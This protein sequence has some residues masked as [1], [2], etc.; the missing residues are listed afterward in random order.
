MMAT[1]KTKICPHIFP[2]V[3]VVWL[4]FAATAVAREYHVALTG[5]G[6]NDGSSARPLRNIQTAAE[7]VLPGDVVTVHTGIYRER[8]DPP[9]GGTSDRKRIVFQA[10]PGERVEISGAEVVTNWTRVQDNIWRAVLPNSFFGGFNPFSDLIHGDWFNPLGRRHHTGA[11]YLKGHWLWEAAQ[12][13]ELL[14]PASANAQWFAHVDATNTTIWAQFPDADPNGQTVEVNVRQTVFY[15]RQPGV[16]YLTVRGFILRNAATPWAPPTAEQIGLIGT[17]WSRGWIIENNSVRYSRCSGITLG[18]YGDE[19]DNTSANSAEGYVVTI[20][21]A[22]TNGWNG[23]TVGHHIIRDNVISDC[24]Q[25]GICGSLGAIFC[26]VSNNVIHDIYVQRKFHGAELGGIKFHAAIDTVICNNHVH[27]AYRGLWLDWMAQGTRVSGNLFHDN[28][29]EDFFTEVNHGPFVVDNNIFLSPLNLRDMSQGGA[30][31]HNL[32]AGAILSVPERTR[33]TP[34]QLP[35]S[36][37]IAGLTNTVG[38]DQRFYNN[39]FVGNGTAGVQTNQIMH[40]PNNPD[41][42]PFGLSLGLSAYDVRAV[43]IHVAGNVYLNGAKPWKD[44]TNATVN[45]SFN[46]D[47]TLLRGWDG[48]ILK[49]KSD[50]Q[51]RSAPARFVTTELLGKSR[52]SGASYE[53]ADGSALRIDRDYFGEKRRGERPVP[54]PFATVSEEKLRIMLRPHNDRLDQ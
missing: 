24:E 14:N 28:I 21:R 7:R 4:A 9:L 11:V 6:D 22:L 38:G 13:E 43:P 32:M 51:W 40:L 10:A 18:K 42:L 19:W 44:E 41:Y 5:D 20:Q 45:A 30:F 52:I 15:P 16:N 17:H 3:S 47:V 46:P 35:H 49:F 39:L 25:T 29:Y 50:S 31:I 27:D 33:E 53:N 34:F 48:F 26:T 8:I 12:L 1:M 2:I 37:V 23:E 54:G 36:V